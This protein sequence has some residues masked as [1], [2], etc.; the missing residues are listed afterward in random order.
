MSV[1]EDDA[2]FQKLAAKVR[3]GDISTEELKS[4]IDR[5]T[6]LEELLV[7]KK[8][9]LHDS[10]EALEKELPA[11]LVQ[12]TEQVEAG[13]QCKDS[14]VTYRRKQVDKDL[15]RTRLAIRQRWKTFVNR[16]TNIFADA[17]ANLSKARISAI[18]SGYK[19]MFK[20]IMNVGDVVPDLQRADDREDLHVQLSEFHG[21]HSLSA[22]ALLPESYRNALAISVFLAAAMKHSGAPRF[23]VLDDV[24]S[25]FD[26]GHQYFLMEL[27]RQTLQHPSNPNG[28]QF[29]I[30]SHDSLLEK[31]FDKHGGTGNWRHHRLQGAPPMGQ[32]LGQ[33]QDADRLKSN[34]QNLLSAGQVTQAE[35]LIRQYLEYKLQQI[36]RRVDIP[37]PIDFVIKDQS[38]MVSNCI[39]AITTSV[40]L[41]R[42]AG[43]LVLDVQQVQDLDTVHVPA[44][45]GN[46]VSHYETA[47][48]SNLSAPALQ[49]VV[50]TIDD[51]AECFRFDDNST[52]TVVRRW[53]KSLEA[54][55]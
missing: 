55:A 9:E 21:Q 25:S 41:H 6:E 33:S 1:D 11:S 45:I 34:I 32:V 50:S 18:D 31:Y 19:D 43:S 3:V 17:E 46:W 30:L 42:S 27:I 10:K 16:A 20:R 37:V 52:G 36:I 24:T 22:R 8:R 38:R 40:S 44:L 7:T 35:H 5:S 26:A 4:T 12:L 47:T 49:G 54:R 2:L 51:I 28:L 23:V 53:Y 29:L 14:V 48:G 39:N 13:R 15:I